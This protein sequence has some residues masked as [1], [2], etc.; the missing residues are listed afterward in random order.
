MHDNAHRTA[1]L[2]ALIE[3]A[4]HYA[5]I[6][7]SPDRSITSW[8]AGAHRLLGWTE[9]EVLGQSADLIYM[10]EDREA[11]I[12]DVEA[13]TAVEKGRAE[14]ER[15]HLR[16]DGSRFWGSGLL[17]P[18]NG[19]G[20]T[21]FVKIMRDRTAKRQA[22]KALKES[23]ER[24]RTLA[25]HI[26]QLVWRSHSDGER[27]WPS[28]QWI[29]YTGLSAAKSLGLGWLDA[30]HPDDR[31]LTMEAWKESER[32]GE[33]YVEHRTRRA[34]DGEYRWFQSRASRLTDEDG[35]TIEW[36]GTST[37]VHELRRLHERQQ[38]LLRELHHRSR[39]L[40]A[41]IAAI[42]QRT[43]ATSSNLDDFRQTFPDRIGA[44]A[45]VQGLVTRDDRAEANLQEIIEAEIAAH[46]VDLGN[47]LEISG[48]PVRLRDR[49]AETLGL[50]LHELATN[51]VKYGA[52][53][54][55]HGQLNINWKRN[56]NGLRLEWRE[57]GIAQ[58]P[59]PRRRGY[60]SELIEVALPHALGAQTALTFTE[61]Q[62]HCTVE[63]PA[64]E[65][66]PH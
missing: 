64:H 52:L 4:T 6:T 42:A 8:N 22:E 66:D 5:I 49:A 65:L 7:F 56:D 34:A 59:E 17:M 38:V 31:H 39:N 50:A 46:G 55:D 10:E 23:E 51:A 18:L 28:P 21:G 61:E 54:N 2:N 53:A 35:Q 14:D 60:G 45:R 48:P 58:K 25:E 9:D 57:V 29:A 12:P 33:F 15:W 13:Q 24:F 26:P 63:I 40:M 3:G 27:V 62:V 41:V 43:L 32:T 16:K 36:F 47:R 30:I 44:L 37:D 11:G 1:L 19:E 20:V